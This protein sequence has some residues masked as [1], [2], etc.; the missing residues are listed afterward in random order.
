MLGLGC[1]VRRDRL[2][3]G[4]S[5]GKGY[6]GEF[7]IHCCATGLGEYDMRWTF[8]HALRI[9]PIVAAMIGVSAPQAGAGEALGD[10]DWLAASDGFAGLSREHASIGFVAAAQ[11]TGIRR[12]PGQPP[13]VP[14]DD[15]PAIDP[16]AVPPPLPNL[17]RE[18]IPVPDRWRLIDVFGV[19]ERWWD[20]YNQNTLKSDRPIFD[21]W[22]VNVAA[23]SD[24]IVEPR[25]LP[26]P[27]GIQ[28][29][30]RANTLDVFGD[31]NQ[32]FFNENL[33]TSFSLIKGDTVYRPPDIELRLTPVFNFNYTDVEERRV[34]FIDPARG[35]TRTDGHIALQ[36][37]FLDYHIR[38]VSDRFDFDSIRVG[39]QPIQADF[40]GFLFQDQQLGVR[41]FGTRNNNIFQYNLAYFRRLDKDTNSGL[42]DV[43][44]EL[45]EDDVFLANVYWQDFPVLG[46]VSQATVVHNRN[47]END[48]FFFNDNG[49]LE[50]PASIG[51]ERP[52]KYDVTYLGLN[53]DG[54]FGRVN[55]SGS[56]YYAFGD[57]EPNQF[58]GDGESSRISAFF[59]ALE[60]SIDF[61]W[62]RLRGSLLYAS[63]DSDPFDDTEGGFDAIFENPQF[64]G[65]DTS[66]FIRQ[67]VPLIGGGGVALSGRN[68][69]L[70]ALRS[71]KEQGQ[72]NFNNPGLRLIGV[73][74]DLDVT[75]E[76]RLS[77]NANYLAFDDTSSLEFLRNQGGIDRGIGWDLSAA[78]TWRPLFT[79]NV[80]LRA[81]GAV[82]VAEDGFKELY[83]TDRNQDL[84]YSVL[85]NL[86]LTF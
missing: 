19:S 9:A 24:T 71:S 4:S 49:F 79:Q 8:K 77:A 59:A 80:I 41:L 74:T 68:A 17:P 67:A 48:E 62:I 18:S 53:G 32:F 5:R 35:T 20:P 14:Q 10:L 73:G 76:I 42:N 34:L 29:T 56:F 27:V 65:A 70:P 63:G 61:S 84:F 2:G 31:V 86:I 72:S 28:T 60:P 44:D 82:L 26:T 11:D 55:L 46:F 75:P 66:F 64:A 6:G 25:R 30:D 43:G 39:I 12:R 78:L 54:H 33:I 81:S 23:I 51:D 58:R 45:R 57:D 3:K 22:F 1:V 13:P 38:N 85:V 47:R 7:R 37:A 40:R 52:R 15:F 16:S 36:E 83:E 50:R 21:D 69:V